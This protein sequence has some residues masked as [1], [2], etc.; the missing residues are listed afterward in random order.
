LIFESSRWR[1]HSE[2]SSAL[3]RIATPGDAGAN[4]TAAIRAAPK[5]LD[6][7]EKLGHQPSQRIYENSVLMDHHTGAISGEK[8]I[9]G[10]TF[11]R[12][13]RLISSLM[14]FFYQYPS[15]VEHTRPAP[16][17]AAI[18]PVQSRRGC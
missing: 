8:L 16:I 17:S 9:D 11:V 15:F 6:T 4:R 13:L 2:S 5:T 12:L 10:R 14:E 3:L 7:G 18:S 1:G